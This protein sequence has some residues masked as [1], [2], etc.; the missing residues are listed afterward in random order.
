MTAKIWNISSLIKEDFCIRKGGL[1]SEEE[2]EA[3]IR[4]LKQPWVYFKYKLKLA[5]FSLEY[6]A[7]KIQI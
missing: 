4:E 6:F 3:G 2:E 7:W 1:G 5:S